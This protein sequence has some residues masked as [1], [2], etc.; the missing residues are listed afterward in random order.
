M[1]KIYA[2]RPTF[3]NL[4]SGERIIDKNSRG[5]PF[6]TIIAHPEGENI[7]IGWSQCSRHDHFSRH[8]GT[9][10]AQQRLEDSPIILDMQGNIIDSGS[11]DIQDVFEPQMFETILKCVYEISRKPS[12][13]I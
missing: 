5:I 11:I 1:L 13:Y 3:V 9:V 12:R 7:K 6:G 4:P 8:V 2:R 10:M